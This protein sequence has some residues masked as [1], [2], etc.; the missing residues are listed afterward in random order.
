M[1][2][3]SPISFLVGRVRDPTKIDHR[4]KQRYQLILSSI[5]AQGRVGWEVGEAGKAGWPIQAL[6]RGCGT[7]GLAE[8]L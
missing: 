5:R 8:F 6:A 2:P 7:R 3:F 4:K 1:V